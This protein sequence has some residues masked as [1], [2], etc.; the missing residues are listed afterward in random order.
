MNSV[1]SRPIWSEIQ[2]QNGRVTPFITR[3]SVIA[4][5]RAGSVRPSKFTGTSATLKSRAI[6]AICAVAIRPPE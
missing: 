2:P 5:V 1:F 4:K 3:S 6:G